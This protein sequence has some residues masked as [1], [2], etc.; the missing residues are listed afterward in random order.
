LRNAPRPSS[1]VTNG[2]TN[3]VDTL[4]SGVDTLP[5]GVSNSVGTLPSGVYG[6]T[7]PLLNATQHV[8][9]HIDSI[10]ATCLI[11]DTALDEPIASGI[12]FFRLDALRTTAS[13]EDKRMGY[14]IDKG[15]TEP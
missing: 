7:A 13:H 10:V 14:I 12:P 1:G 2:V 8:I 6:L 3:G 15:A 5:N 9:S 4:P 11:I